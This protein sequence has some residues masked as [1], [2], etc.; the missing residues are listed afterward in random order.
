MKEPHSRL[1]RWRLKLQKFDYQICYKKGK[2]NT[3]ADGLSRIEINMTENESVLGNPGDID[4]EINQYIRNE[5]NKNLTLEEVQEL[6][7][8][9][10]PKI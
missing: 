1:V 7:D 10:K 9:I 5:K 2:Q 6:K 8:I 4:E 3:N